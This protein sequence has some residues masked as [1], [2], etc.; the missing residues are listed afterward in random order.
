MSKQA[1]SSFSNATFFPLS[2]ILEYAEGR[3]EETI[4][5]KGS[6]SLLQVCVAQ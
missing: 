6:P 5:N 2:T 1:P 4:K 3:E